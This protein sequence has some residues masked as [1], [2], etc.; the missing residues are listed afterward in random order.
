M[1]QL[2]VHHLSGAKPLVQGADQICEDIFMQPSPPGDSC[3]VVLRRQGVPPGNA[4]SSCL[5]KA[6][7][8]HARSRFSSSSFT[9]ANRV[10]WQIGR[11]SFEH[12]GGHFRSLKRVVCY[13]SAI[14][15]CIS[16]QCII[17]RALNLWFRALI[18]SV[19][20]FSCNPRHPEIPAWW[21]SGDKVYP[22]A[23]LLF[24]SC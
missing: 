17:F 21:S 12:W 4:F 24:V 2:P 10:S 9:H 14:S 7:D 15:K 5:A 1:H 20:T 8:M 16:F 3:L 11:C 18:R 13:L 23:T 19:K 22:Q 6:Q